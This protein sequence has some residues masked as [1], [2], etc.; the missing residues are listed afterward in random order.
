M[1]ELSLIEIFDA[2]IDHADNSR[3]AM[4]ALRKPGLHD[5]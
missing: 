4:K 2:A 3:G 1:P 5:F